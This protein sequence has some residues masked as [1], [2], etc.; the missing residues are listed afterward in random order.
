MPFG[1]STSGT[2]AAGPCGLNR[3]GNHTRSWLVENS[4]MAGDTDQRWS[5]RS[6]DDNDDSAEKW[7]FQVLILRW[8]VV[9]EL[10][11]YQPSGDHQD[12]LI[13]QENVQVGHLCF[14]DTG[15]DKVIV[16]LNRQCILGREGG[17]RWGVGETTCIVES[18]RHGGL[19]STPGPKNLILQWV[20]EIC[21]ISVGL[22]R[23]TPIQK[24]C[25]LSRELEDHFVLTFLAY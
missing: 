9:S 18:W 11:C 2:T 12:V 5:S 23:E 1:F 20:E 22:N 7:M 15:W 21:L 16:D 6:K 24:G 3:A 8:G 4:L 14:T 25:F 13:A 10:H 19:V 17:W